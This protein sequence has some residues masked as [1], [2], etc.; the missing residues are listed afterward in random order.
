MTTSLEDTFFGEY[1]CPIFM[2]VDEHPALERHN[3]QSDSIRQNIKARK[4]LEATA[5]SNLLS[6]C[7]WDMHKTIY[8]G[9]LISITN[10]FHTTSTYY[11]QCTSS[12]G[13]MYTT[14]LHKFVADDE[15]QEPQVP[16][17]KHNF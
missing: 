9:G 12:T 11:F 2:N 17:T 15:N 1:C 16:A 13:F 3:I 14:C 10:N 7:G 8:V 6:A 4:K 5:C